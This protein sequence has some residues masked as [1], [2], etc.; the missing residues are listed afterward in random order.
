MESIAI[1]GGGGIGSYF[2]RSIA[3]LIKKEQVENK[4]FQIFDDDIVSYDNIL[5]QNFDDDDIS[6]YKAE[7]LALKYNLDCEDK[8]KFSNSRVTSLD[9]LNKFDII[10]SAVDNND[11]RKLLYKTD[12][13]WIDLRSEGRTITYYIK[14]KSHTED[15]MLK[16]LSD[17]ASSSCQLP[18]ELSKNMIQ[19]GNVIIAEIGA[20][21]LLNHIR[22]DYN[23]P[24][25]LMRF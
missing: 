2:V 14:H 18:F 9:V 13:F 10:I 1:V 24:Y 23:A 8:L 17:E 3:S 4:I 11:F 20:Q 21:L 25:K 7:T 22:E 5:Y 15:F 16:T 6:D 19:L 12:K